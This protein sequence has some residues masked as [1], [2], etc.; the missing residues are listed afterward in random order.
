MDGRTG[1]S[2][3]CSAIIPMGTA[4]R[5]RRP[6]SQPSGEADDSRLFVY[7]VTRATPGLRTSAPSLS[8]CEVVPWPIASPG[9]RPRPDDLVFSVPSEQSLASAPGDAAA[10]RIRRGNDTG[11]LEVCCGDER[12]CRDP[13]EQVCLTF[14]Q[15][16]AAFENSDEVS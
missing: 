3:A 2:G 6:T 10:S 9:P 1:R 8:D 5:V 4:P 16:G 12:T 11:F 13:V 15:G 14:L 7:S